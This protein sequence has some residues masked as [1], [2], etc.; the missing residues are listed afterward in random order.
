[1]CEHRNLLSSLPSSTE[2]NWLSGTRICCPVCS[3]VVNTL[4]ELSGHYRMHC[5]SGQ[6]VVCVISG[7]TDEFQVY[8]SY[9]SHMSRC[10]KNQ[11]VINVTYLQR[12]DVCED[13]VS[14][15]CSDSECSEENVY[16]RYIALFLLKLQESCMLPCSTIQTVVDGMKHERDCDLGKQVHT[17]KG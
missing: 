11:G 16:T 6:K 17:R 12:D 9:T 2:Q 13:T 8:S 7:C 5:T 3:V 15:N 14:S 4:S 1:M 10:H